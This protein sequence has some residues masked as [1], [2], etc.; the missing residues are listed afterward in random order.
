MEELENV[1]DV[2]YDDSYIKL[3]ETYRLDETYIKSVALDPFEFK[4]RRQDLRLS[5][6]MGTLYLSVFPD[7]FIEGT[8]MC[9]TI[10][11]TRDE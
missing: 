2:Y 9:Q 5:V 6:G 11:W 1:S 4:N 10:E 7:P 3:T 8:R